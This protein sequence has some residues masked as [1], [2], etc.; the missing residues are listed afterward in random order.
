MPGE[1]SMRW[2]IAA[3][4]AGVLL[5]GC[6][7]GGPN[8][9]LRPVCARNDAPAVML[10][11]PAKGNAQYPYFRLRIERPIGQVAGQDVVVRDPDAAGPS[12]EW[13]DASGCRVIRSAT[14]T[15]ATFGPLRGDSSVTVRLRTT[16]PDGKPFAWEGVAPWHGET[17]VC[18]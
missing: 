9:T 8:A 11:L 10:Q 1:I 16:A 17:L 6:A 13:C 14:A 5:A 3:A 15:T 2:R 18:G 4:L 12:A 7:H